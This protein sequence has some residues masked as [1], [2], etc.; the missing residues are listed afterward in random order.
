M[1]VEVF[2]GVA[3]DFKPLTVV[4]FHCP[5]CGKRMRLPAEMLID[6]VADKIE[7]YY[8]EINK[9][10]QAENKRLREIIE[11]GGLI[12]TIKEVAQRI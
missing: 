10:L 1:K 5:T 3:P 12:H 7:E 11:T 8:R 4:E 9:H 6:R 2:T